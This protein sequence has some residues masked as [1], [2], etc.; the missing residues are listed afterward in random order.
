MLLEAKGIEKRYGGVRALKH[1]SFDLRAG[2][3]HAVVGENGAGKSTL[4][5]VLTGAVQPDAGTVRLDGAV[6][7]DNSP[8]RSRELGIAAI[9]QQPAIFPDLTVA[10]N[11]ALANE[12]GGLARRVDWSARRVKARE[13]IEAIGAEIDPDREAGTLSM[14][15]QQLVEIAKALGSN[16]RVLILDEP[17]AS[18]TERETDRL[19]GIIRRLSQRGAGVVYISHRLEELAR[20]A[21]RITVLRDGETIE[22]R[23]AA[24]TDARTLIRLMAGRD[25]SAVFPKRSV[26][27]GEPV[28]EVKNVREA[29]FTVRAGEIFGIAGLVG[30]GRTEL[31]EALFGISPAEKGSIRIRGEE[32][33]IRRPQDAIRAGIAYVPEDRRRHGVVGALPVRANTTLAILDR[34]SRGAILETEEERSLAETWVGQLGIK[35]DGIDAPVSSL[36]GGN[37]QKVAI[38]R[39]IASGPSVLILDEPTQGIDVGAKSECHRL[40]CDLAERGLAVVMIS[41]ELAEI[42]GMSDRIAV[43]RDGRIAGVMNRSDA[44]S[45]AI[46]GLALGQGNA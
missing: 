37:Q 42:M 41:S 36:S 1:V 34:I 17:T 23:R 11:I 32:V 6:I 8:H 3:V 21:D 2:E 31:A 30:S 45:E 16:V 28:L 38:A 29:S 46:L 33:A 22:T 19:F 25:L 40:M 12:P 9:Y 20:I 4:I 7:Q 24:D 10:E 26:P 27:I 39:W 14:P 13:L 5:K 35:T 18:L 15:E 43:M 44:T